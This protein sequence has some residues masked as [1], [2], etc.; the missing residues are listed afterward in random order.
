MQ[1][2]KLRFAEYNVRYNDDLLKGGQL[3]KLVG[4]DG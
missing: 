3:S 2:E 4:G 1:I